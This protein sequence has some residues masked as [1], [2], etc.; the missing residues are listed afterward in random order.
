M[1][2]AEGKQPESGDP[3][4]VL[5]EMNSGEPGAAQCLLPIFK[6]FP[7]LWVP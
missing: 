5:P 2:S 1:T 6:S 4:V 7:F 3:V